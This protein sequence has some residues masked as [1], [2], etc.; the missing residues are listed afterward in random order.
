M[1]DSADQ[2]DRESRRYRDDTYER[3]E[4][5]Y[6]DEYDAGI[7][8][9]NFVNVIDMDIPFFQLVWLMFKVLLATLVAAGILSLFIMLIQWIL[10]LPAVQEV[11]PDGA[12][13]LRNLISF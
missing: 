4:R 13:W 9:V 5:Y 10:G 8:E 3:D 7:D 2:Y 1:R 11:L 12:S 6:D